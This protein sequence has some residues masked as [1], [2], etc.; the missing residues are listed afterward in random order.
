MY[1]ILINAY[2]CCPG[3]GS[4]QGMGWHW[5]TGLAQYCDLH[6]ISEG[7]YRPQVEAWMAQPENKEVAQRMHFYWN[8]VSDTV[9][10]RC[11]NQGNWL[12]YFS[13]ERWQRK[14]E[15][16]AYEI[17][18][19]HK[20]DILHQLNMTGFREPGYLWRVSKKT[21]IPFVWGPI[22]GMM[23]YPY[24]YFIDGKW[25]VCAFFGIKYLLNKIQRQY[26]I[27]VKLAL[28]QASLLIAATPASVHVIN[29]IHKYSSILIP[30]T[31]CM[32][33]TGAY[34]AKPKLEKK[35]EVIW[36]GKFDYRKRLDIALNAIAQTNNNNIHLSVYGKGNPQQ[37]RESRLLIE[38]LGLI[39]RVHLMGQCSN[40][41]V[42]IAMKHA[43]LMLFTSVCEETSTVVLEA[44]SNHLPVVCFNEC[45]M[46]VVVDDTVGRAISFSNPKQSY[47]DFARELDYFYEH[48]DA[49]QKCAEGCVQRAQELSWDNKIKKLIDLYD[50]KIGKY[51]SKS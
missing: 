6:I 9:R 39:N 51:N 36:V 4:E 44:I 12:F 32:P 15:K 24:R 14:T 10:R 18:K 29:H 40:E 46:A 33:M 35:L 42:N 48:R 28:K 3:M 1:T 2:T 37:E 20:I 8:P 43:D 11:W 45:G 49:L 22:G 27:R 38:N 34:P 31:G 26:S 23:Q 13:Y 17:I 5:I 25:L 7:E 47:S 30:E 19:E 21:G 50:Q 16:I 41:E